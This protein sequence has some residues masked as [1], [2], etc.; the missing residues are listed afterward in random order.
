MTALTD[1]EVVEASVAKRLDEIQEE[2]SNL[3]AD[4]RRQAE[5]WAVQRYQIA[6]AIGDVRTDL[7]GLPR[8][9]RGE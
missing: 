5:C 1:P 9:P 6:A 3:L 4:M 2:M 7:N 8:W